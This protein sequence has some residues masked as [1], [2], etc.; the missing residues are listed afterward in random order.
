[1]SSVYEPYKFF[2]LE[3]YSS[4]E[5]TAALKIVNLIID[6][7]ILE[8][9]LQPER[10]IVNYQYVIN[11]EFCNDLDIKYF[12]FKVLDYF[13]GI[14]HREVGSVSPY[15]DSTL[16][17]W[18]GETNYVNLLYFELNGYSNTHDR[19]VT[20][21]STENK[22]N[23]EIDKEL[24]NMY[25]ITS[26]MKIHKLIKELIKDEVKELVKKIKMQVRHPHTRYEQDSLYAPNGWSV[27]FRSGDEGNWRD[28][29]HGYRYYE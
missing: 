20:L 2:S 4:K 24:S 11:S 22:L 5:M 25:G 1:M 7:T 17:S 15:G 26:S 13:G 29:T 14:L 27:D 16:H 6:S 12:E 3:E 9:Y 23:I 8:D 18:Q 19:L 21:Q 28:D 10:N